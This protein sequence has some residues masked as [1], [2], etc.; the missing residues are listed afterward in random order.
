MIKGLKNFSN[1]CIFIG[2][3]LILSSLTLHSQFERNNIQNELRPSTDSTQIPRTDTTKFKM[4]TVGLSKPFNNFGAIELSKPNYYKNITKKDI[5]FDTYYTIS[6]ILKNRH[7]GFPMSLGFYGMNNTL[8]L[9]GGNPQGLNVR[10]NGLSQNEFETGNCNLSLFPSEAL[11]SIELYLGS[12]AVIYGDNSTGSLL[13]LKEIEHNTYLPYTKLW[14]SQGSSDMIAADGT[15]SQNFAKNFNIDIGFR[16]FNSPGGYQNQWINSWNLRAKARWNIDNLTSISLSDIFNNYGIGE[17]GGSNPATSPN[18][19]DEVSANPLFLN[20]NSRLFKH[21]LL[22]TFYKSLDSSRNF[23]INSKFAYMNSDK[24]INDANSLITSPSDSIPF[25]KYTAISFANNTNVETDIGFFHLNTGI[26]LS[27]DYYRSNLNTSDS[28]NN[29]FL[30][31]KNDFTNISFYGLAKLSILKNLTLSGGSRYGNEFGRNVLSFGAKIQWNSQD[32]TFLQTLFFDLSKSDRIPSLIEGLNLDNEHH[33]LAFAGL[34]FNIG[35]SKFDILGF[36]RQI[37][38]PILFSFAKDSNQQVINAKFSNGSNERIMGV[39][40]QYSGSFLNKKLIV[41]SFLKSYNSQINSETQAI[42]PNIY[43]GIKTYY[44]ISVGR[45]MM[46]LGLEYEALSSF[47]GLNYMPIYDGYSL[48]NTNS[49]FMGNGLNFFA[50]ARLGDTYVRA[51]FENILGQGYYYTPYYP[52][53]GFHFQ[54][55]FSWAFLN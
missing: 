25:V 48:T 46:R 28:L 3:S 5:V 2:F 19:F 31:G 18:I 13:N 55:S 4:D 7:I 36:F 16:S 49:G 27:Y 6:D 53:L 17:N 24:E 45:S 44:I 9:L 8:Y 29:A 43:A 40:I 34:T 22:L 38:L 54:F 42:F 15:F 1:Y 14:Y 30:V 32:T 12:D 26:D 11:E 23:V 33:Y 10:F 37:D 51:K 52:E 50:E 20:T 41:E 39:E 21:N 47:E 35:Q